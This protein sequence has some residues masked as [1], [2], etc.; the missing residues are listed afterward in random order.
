MRKH[1]I[2]R[3]QT[4]REAIVHEHRANPERI[5]DDLDNAIGCFD[6]DEPMRS[7][8]RRRMLIGLCNL[9]EKHGDTFAGQRYAAVRATAIEEAMADIAED[10]E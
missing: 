3:E 5:A 10:L 2:P 6:L 1:V 9:L 8:C 4:V 7:Y